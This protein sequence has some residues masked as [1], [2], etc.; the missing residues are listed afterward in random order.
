MISQSTITW[1]PYLLIFHLLLL[2]H[3][4][5]YPT[6][7]SVNVLLQ[8]TPSHLS[9]IATLNLVTC[10]QNISTNQNQV[11]LW[12]MKITCIYWPTLSKTNTYECTLY[13]MY[14]HPAINFTFWNEWMQFM[15]DLEHRWK[16]LEFGTVC[17]SIRLWLGTHNG[18]QGKSCWKIS[19]SAGPTNPRQHCGL[20]IH[21]YS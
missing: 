21:K 10:V 8:K 3:P 9:L 1:P 18:I 12:N 15:F 6:S 16:V 5:F 14:E 20:I 13:R 11:I 19:P 4:L 7:A 2:L 17:A